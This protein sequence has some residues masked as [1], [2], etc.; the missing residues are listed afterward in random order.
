VCGPENGRAGAATHSGTGRPGKAAMTRRYWK[1]RVF[2]I[3][4]RSG[5][6]FWER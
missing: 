5:Q 1:R 3:W 4:L 2:L 6:A